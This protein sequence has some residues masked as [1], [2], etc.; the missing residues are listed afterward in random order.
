M[1][2]RFRKISEQTYHAPYNK[3][4]PIKYLCK[5]SFSINQRFIFT[6]FLGCSRKTA[7]NSD[8]GSKRNQRM[9]NCITFNNIYQSFAFDWLN[10][11]TAPKKGAVQYNHLSA[12]GLRSSS[13]SARLCS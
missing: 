12:S 13:L 10:D 7:K 3:Q 11:D 8:D 5:R 2:V 6:K 4:Q 1:V 9:G